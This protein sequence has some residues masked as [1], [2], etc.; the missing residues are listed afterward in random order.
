MNNNFIGGIIIMSKKFRNKRKNVEELAKRSIKILKS[1]KVKI[2]KDQKISLAPYVEESLTEVVCSRIEGIISKADVVIDSKT[3]ITT[4]AN[5]MSAKDLLN[6]SS[7]IDKSVG[8]ITP[9][10]VVH[11]INK[12]EALTTFDFTNESIIGSLLRTSTL[13]AIYR[14][15]KEAWVELND[16][17]KTGFTNVLF[18]PKILVFLEDETGVVKKV[19]LFV[20]LLLLSVPSPKA[21]KDATTEEEP[22]NQVII[23]RYIDDVFKSAV[24]C[25]AKKLIITPFC[26]K[27]FL[28]EVYD[29]SEAWVNNTQLQKNIENIDSVNFAINDENLYVVFAG[30]LY[31]TRLLTN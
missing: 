24:L 12:K 6:T 30:S 28:K 4:T 20:N 25:G 21:I 10:T 29:T 15:I 8:D 19:P 9:N 2:N 23:N 17:D 27:L 31:K 5:I 22:E 11:V 16:D 1:G 14:K 7:M 18:I 3:S 26:H 13:A